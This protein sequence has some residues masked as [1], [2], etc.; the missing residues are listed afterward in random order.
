MRALHRDKWN[1]S[2]WS[3]VCSKHFKETDYVTPP[4]LPNPRLK[5]NTVPSIVDF[6]KHLQ[7]PPKIPGREVAQICNSTDQSSPLDENMLIKHF[8]HVTQTNY[9]HK[10][11][12]KRRSEL[13]PT[14]VKLKREIKVLLQKIRRQTKRISSLKD[15]SDNDGW[16]GCRTISP[17]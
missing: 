17:L 11:E 14:K 7:A 2:T 16:Y 3:F 1:P 9:K 10:Q 6:P 12:R 15:I 13:T 8:T 5:R 4:G